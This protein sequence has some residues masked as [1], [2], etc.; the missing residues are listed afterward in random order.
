MI[1]GGYGRLS[2]LFTA[3]LRFL[4]NGRAFPRDLV[5]KVVLLAMWGFN[6]SSMSLL[7]DRQTSPF[8]GL[9]G[10]KNSVNW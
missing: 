7:T 8:T 3:P 4:V 10:E 1:G 6:A 2:N 9:R 5:E